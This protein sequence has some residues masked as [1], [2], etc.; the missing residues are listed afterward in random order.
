MNMIVASRG[1]SKDL[2]VLK[3]KAMNFPILQTTK[4]Q[5]YCCDWNPIINPP[6]Q[7]NKKQKRKQKNTHPSYNLK[8]IHSL[9]L[10]IVVAFLSTFSVSINHFQRNRIA[11]AA[12]L[13]STLKRSNGNKNFHLGG[14]LREKYASIHTLA[15]T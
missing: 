6:P 10:C 2:L 3:N 12:I 13:C 7:K 1:L 14:N 9:L 4:V 8:N 15:K 11:A 5:V